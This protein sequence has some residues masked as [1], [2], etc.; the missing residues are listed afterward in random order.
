MTTTHQTIL[1]EVLQERYTLAAFVYQDEQISNEAQLENLFM[2]EDPE[3][4]LNLLAVLRSL[5]A[6]TF[7]IQA[8]GTS[9]LINVPLEG[10]LYSLS[11]RPINLYQD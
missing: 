5:P 9:L 7:P 6:D 8:K 4:R 1:V 11:V 3:E 2:Q 10:Q